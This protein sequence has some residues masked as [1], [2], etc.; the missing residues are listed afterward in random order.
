MSKFSNFQC[1]I[2]EKTILIVEKICNVNISKFSHFLIMFQ[3]ED[4]IKLIKEICGEFYTFNMTKQ[5]I[6]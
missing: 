3:R 5:M 2:K 1:F 6:W 4:I